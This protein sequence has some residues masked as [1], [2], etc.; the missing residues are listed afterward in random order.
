VYLSEKVFNHQ[1]PLTMEGRDSEAFVP[2]ED[3]LCLTGI[4]VVSGKL[5]VEDELNTLASNISIRRDWAAVD[6]FTNYIE[7][8]HME[9]QIAIG[10]LEEQKIT[11]AENFSMTVPLLDGGSIR[12]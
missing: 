7:S 11:F 3:G 10:I 2:T 6:Y 4:E 8:L 9:K 1:H 5:T 12:I